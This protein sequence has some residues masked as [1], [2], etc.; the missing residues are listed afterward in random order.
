M[1]ALFWCS[2]FNVAAVVSRLS[3]VVSCWAKQIFSSKGFMIH[4]RHFGWG[5]T[6]ILSFDYVQNKTTMSPKSQDVIVMK[7]E[8]TPV[9]VITQAS[10]KLAVQLYFFISF[11]VATCSAEDKSYSV[12][13][14]GSWRTWPNQCRHGSES[15]LPQGYISFWR[16]KTIHYVHH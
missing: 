11:Q 14:C 8:A 10:G 3:L 5:A 15:R 7:A 4:K 2:N 13:V 16:Q 1:M 9:T 12:C 6:L